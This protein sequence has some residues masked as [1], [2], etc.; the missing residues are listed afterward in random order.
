MT[1]GKLR[2]GI[3]GLGGI[4]SV[5]AQALQQSTSCTLTAVCDIDPTKTTAL[6][7]DAEFFTE[8]EDI[9]TSDECDAL[10]ICTPPD[11][12]REMATAA[13][14]AGKHVL[15]EKPM[16]ESLTS[17]QE[18]LSV[19]R[20]TGRVLTVGYNHRF[21]KGV[22][23]VR[24]SIAEE[25]IGKLH[26][27]RAFTG[28][29]GL[30]EF[31]APWMYDRKV[32]GGGTLADNGTHLLDLVASLMGD[33]ASVDARVENALWGLEVEDNAFLHL[34]D[35]NGAYCE[36][37]SSWTEWKGY[38]FF[39]EAYGEKG[40]VQMYYAPMFAR[41][42]RMADDRFSSTS[43]RWF[44][45]KDIFKEKFR[46]W[47]ST[48][49]ETFLKEFD[50]FA[51]L[52]KGNVESSVIATGEDGCRAVQLANAAYESSMTNAPVAI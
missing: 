22:D 48:V 23:V 11:T 42:I 36:F 40:M 43:E 33:I 7:N 26:F 52:T 10:V 46:G 30:S 12:H 15:V 51:S 3:V 14:L 45:W 19:A 2:F 13:M 29:T 18:M 21:F 47:Q 4:G 8:F 39:V 32:M 9:A 50:E 17:C 16:A 38:R 44:F 1:T 20:E 27:L 35:N 34:T 25:T 6:N 37:H 41:R 28:H 24:R 31:K 49:I 5:R